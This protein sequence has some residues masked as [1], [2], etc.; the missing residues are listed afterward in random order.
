MQADICDPEAI[1]EILAQMKP[2]VVFH[3]AAPHAIDGVN[4]SSIY[5]RTVVHGDPQPV[6]HFSR[7]IWQ[8]S[9]SS[10]ELLRS[11]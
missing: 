1:S 7:R 8:T 5:R 9:E 6:C 10:Q 4:D 2:E 3:V 11:F